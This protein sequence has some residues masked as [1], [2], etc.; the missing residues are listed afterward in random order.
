VIL[1]DFNNGWG[2]QVE[3]RKY[4]QRMLSV[5][6]RAWYQ[7]QHSN[8]II[9]S[10]W[11]DDRYHAKVTERLRTNPVHKLA[12]ISFM[13]PAILQPSW[14]QGL[15]DQIYCIGYY[16]GAGEIDLWAMIMHEYFQHD[17]ALTT[18][19]QII[20]PFL[21]YNRKP[22][23]HRVRLVD[24][25]RADG[26]E[27]SG[28]VTLGDASGKAQMALP[29]DVTPSC[30]APNPGTEQYG[31][32]NDIM[33]L[34]NIEIWNQCLLNVVTET[35]YDVDNA[36]FVS[37]KIYKPLVGL[38]PF[39][40]YA[41]NGAS[42]WLQHIGVEPYM[43]DFADISDLDLADPACMAPFLKVLCQQTSGYLQQKYRDLL[44][45]IL[46]NRH[47]FDLHVEHTRQKILDGVHLEHTL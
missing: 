5:Y 6:L 20:R 14:F 37:E 46:H 33:S 9:N 39:L 3:L 22:H 16:K 17:P 32:G 29:H 15:A 13:D 34:G 35:V 25:L 2:D 31:I 19:Q 43:R 45:K 26:C 21:C 12:L 44:P 11:Y 10:T 30:I 18:G 47:Q 8:A 28:V 1:E 4:E 23:W 41:P 24:Q 7:D 38:R 42:A 40:V 27:T 36:W